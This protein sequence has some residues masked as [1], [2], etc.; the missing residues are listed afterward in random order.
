MA[1]ALNENFICSDKQIDQTC[2]S[3]SVINMMKNIPVD[4]SHSFYLSEVTEG[5]LRKLMIN[6]K[7]KSAQDCY[8]ISAIIKPVTI[9]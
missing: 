6:I 5:D 1:Q 7:S 8:G 4:I 9:D 3:E 2:Q